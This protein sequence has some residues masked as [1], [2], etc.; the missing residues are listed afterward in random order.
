[1]ALLRSSRTPDPAPIVRGTRVMLRAPVMAGRQVSD[2]FGSITPRQP[3]AKVMV[4]FFSQT[5][6]LL[7][8]L[9]LAS[10]PLGQVT[11]S[12]SAA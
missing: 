3:D 9:I 6:V 2:P 11:P 1:M 5:R 12:G 8:L 10:V 7:P 4:S